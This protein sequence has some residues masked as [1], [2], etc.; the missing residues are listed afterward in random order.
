MMNPAIR[1]GRSS[2]YLL[3]L[4]GWRAL[5]VIAVMLNRSYAQYLAITS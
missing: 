1:D 2:N 3:T 5:S 4:D